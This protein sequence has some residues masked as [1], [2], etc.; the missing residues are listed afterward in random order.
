MTRNHVLI[1]LAIAGT[2][3]A[4][5][6]GPKQDDPLEPPS[7]EGSFDAS[8]SADTGLA[9]D[10]AAGGD[11]TAAPD[12][13]WDAA[14]P[15]SDTGA[16]AR[17]DATSETCP[18]GGVALEAVGPWQEGKKCWK[19]IV[20]FECVDAIDGGAAFTCFARVSTG[21]LFLATTT[22]I[23]S[24]SDYRVCTDAER[25]RVKMMPELCTK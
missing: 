24:G 16:D 9:S 20:F 25:A 3:A 8:A 10:D 11:P 21:E 18:D 19:G 5:G 2:I 22:H 7:S 6:I 15:P 4:C 14:P 13:A 23:P 17:P 12:A 1:A